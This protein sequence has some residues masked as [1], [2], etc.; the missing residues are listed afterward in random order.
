[1][2]CL[3]RII[4]IPRLDFG[5]ILLQYS[6]Q[7]RYQGNDIFKVWIS[8]NRAFNISLL[9]RVTRC[10]KSSFIMEFVHLP[11]LH[12][13]ST[14]LYFRRIFSL[15]QDWV[16]S[17]QNM[18]PRQQDNWHKNI[19]KELGIIHL[20][21]LFINLFQK[22]WHI[23]CFPPVIHDVHGLQCLDFLKFYFIFQ[24]LMLAPKNRHLITLK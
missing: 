3:V 12:K 14:A 7:C 21:I 10:K 13:V 17:S 22:S 23:P 24:D 6:Q 20:N 4:W 16:K 2:K 18:S 11:E 8:G 1:M 19:F 9:F 15:F 5:G